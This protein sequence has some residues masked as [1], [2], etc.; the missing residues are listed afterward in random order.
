M[1]LVGHGVL[2]FVVSRLKDTPGPPHRQLNLQKI[3]YTNGGWKNESVKAFKFSMASRRMGMGFSAALVNDAGLQH[4]VGI[5]HDGVWGPRRGW[6][7]DFSSW[8]SYL[9]SFAG[10]T[11]VDCVSGIAQDGAPFRGVDWFLMGTVA[12]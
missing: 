5:V 7:S 2:L 8:P 6:E 9:V 11:S 4:C 3:V 1:F 10:G 12:R